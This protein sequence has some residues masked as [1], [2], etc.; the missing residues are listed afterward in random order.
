MILSRR[1]AHHRSCRAIAGAA[2]VLAFVVLSSWSCSSGYDIE[3][4]KA[5]LR[6]WE[7]LDEERRYEYIYTHK[8]S[9]RCVRAIKAQSIYIG[10]DEESVLASWGPPDD[11]SSMN[12]VLTPS[13]GA[14]IVPYTGYR[15]DGQPLGEVFNYQAIGRH[16]LYPPGGSIKVVFNEDCEVVSVMVPEAELV[17]CKV[18]SPGSHITWSPLIGVHDESRS[19]LKNVF[20]QAVVVGECADSTVFISRNG[21]YRMVD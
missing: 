1:R 5:T 8:L 7:R 14:G 12:T 11:P 21:E 9:P 3:S 13:R 16:T 6:K 4:R 2:G 20:S 17:A 10:M 15:P 19:G 18:A